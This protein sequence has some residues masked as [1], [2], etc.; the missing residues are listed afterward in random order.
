[1]WRERKKTNVAKC[2]AKVFTIQLFCR[3]E[4]FQN[5]KETII[6]SSLIFLKPEINNKKVF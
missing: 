4:T 2:V 5:I 1:M 3:I 6:Q